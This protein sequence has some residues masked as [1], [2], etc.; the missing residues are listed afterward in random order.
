MFKAKTFKLHLFL[1]V[2]CHRSSKS[3]QLLRRVYRNDFVI[4][5][6]VNNEYNNPTYAKLI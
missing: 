5:G 4:K 1:I 3:V 6:V 2:Q